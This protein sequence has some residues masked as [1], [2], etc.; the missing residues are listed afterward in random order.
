[1]VKEFGGRARYVV[2]D[3]GA[4]QIATR[5]GVDKYPAIFV[6]EALVARPED[7]YSWGGPETGKY[8]PWSELANRRKFQADLRAMIGIRLSGGDVPSLEMT[9]TMQPER[10]PDVRLTDLEG[11]TFRLSDLRGKMVVVELWA[12][13]CPPC[14]ETMAW[15]KTLDLANTEVV[16]IA[17]ESEREKVDDVIAKFQPPGRIVMATDDVRRAFGG[18]PAVPTMWVADAEGRVVKIFYGAPPTLHEEL[19]A[20]LRPAVS[21]AR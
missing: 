5:F 8:L 17:V 20:L 15:M 10:L 9:K 21:E 6:D 4:S 18:P 7:F 14:L 3:L 19:G 2:E 16:A 12:T 11:K 1:M 13:W